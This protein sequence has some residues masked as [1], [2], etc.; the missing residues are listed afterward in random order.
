MAGFTIPNANQYGVTIQSLDQ[1]EPDSVDFQII[2]NNN[3]G[4]IS[5]GDITTFSSGNGSATLTSSEVFVNSEFGV[6]SGATLTFTAPATDPRFDL[7]VVEFS[8]GSYVYNTVVG[9]TSATNPVFPTPSTTQTVMYALY[10][11]SGVTFD[12]KCVVDKRKYIEHV[13]R[14]GTSATPVALA[15]ENGDFYTRTGTTPA[16]EQSSLYLYTN[17]GWQNLAKY[18]GVRDEGISPF[19]LAGM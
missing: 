11:K 2:G 17:G 4:V 15:P 16:T 5:G 8:G 19:L 3:Y 13:M 14:T 18:E 10:R 9:T 7:I 12:S 6:A 1:A